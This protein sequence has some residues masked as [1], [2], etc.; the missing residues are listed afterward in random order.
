MS[1][2]YICITVTSF[3][4]LTSNTNGVQGASETPPIVQEGVRVDNLIKIQKRGY[5]KFAYSVLL[6]VQLLTESEGENINSPFLRLYMNEIIKLLNNIT[7]ELYSCRFS[8]CW[9][10]N[11]YKQNYQ[12]SRVRKSIGHDQYT[13][14]Y[15]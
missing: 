12:I 13:N 15:S 5:T 11:N 14:R 4:L 1:S 10:H 2:V 6:N 9:S 7:I 8:R 3:E